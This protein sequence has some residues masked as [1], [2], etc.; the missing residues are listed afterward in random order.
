MESKK[1]LV[2]G[3]VGGS[4]QQLFK[5]I[6][7]VNKSNAGPFQILLCVGS[8]FEP[9]TPTSQSVSVEFDDIQLPAELVKYCN[10]ELTVPIPTYFIAYTSN[11]AKYIAKFTDENGSL[12]KNLH[13]LGKSGVK[14]LLNDINVA[15]LSGKVDFPVKEETNQDDLFDMTITKSEIKQVIDSSIDKRIDILLTNQWPRNILHYVEQIPNHIK[16]PFKKGMDGIKEVSDK[17]KPAYHFSKDS[18]YLQ[19]LPFL[20]NSPL[21]KVTRFLSLAP[22]YNDKKEKYLFAM[23]YQPDKEII[24]TDATQNPFEFKQPEEQQQQQALKRQRNNNDESSGNFFFGSAGDSQ[25][26]KQQN[27]QQQQ[28]RHKKNV[29]VNCWFCLSSPD[30]DSGLIVT[31]SSENY[32][33]FAKG[34]VVENHLLIVFIE[35]KPS[36]VSLEESERNDVDNMIEILREYFNK[37]HDQDIVLFERNV[38]LKGQVSHGHLQVIPIPKNLASSVK[39][40]FD[41]HADQ[42]NIQ[43]NEV[44]DINADLLHLS[45]D[46]SYFFVIL[47]DGSKMYSLLP[48]D[49]PFDYQFGRRVIVDLLKTPEKLNWKDCVVEKEKEKLLVS[50]FRESFQPFFDN[51]KLNNDSNDNEQ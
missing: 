35:H 31:V 29:D 25:Y 27:R 26:Q 30:V 24:T 49:K 23:N 18:F 9:F 16:H 8:F 6:E 1:I 40:E 46:S 32:L 17:I 3:D 44:K 5:R 22:V 21:T 39:Q 20:N 13:Y 7:T 10:G 2:C 50:G 51:H 14:T 15:F 37:H 12:C 4:Y 43:F 19:R 48:K 47:P 28:L 45:Q 34:G 11:D 38:P 36:Y 42:V 33:A 41:Q